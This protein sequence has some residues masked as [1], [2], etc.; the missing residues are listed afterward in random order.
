[1]A[2]VSLA[3]QKTCTRCGE[4]KAL[5]EFGTFQE[6]CG[7]DKRRERRRTECK[8]CSAL[9]C[10]ERRERRRA[11]ELQIAEKRWTT[12]KPEKRCYICTETKAIDQF[13]RVNYVTSTG[14]QSWR[15]DSKC[16]ECRREYDRQRYQKNI[17]HEKARQREYTKT[18]RQERTAAKRRYDKRNPE[19]L[20]LWRRWRWSREKERTYGIGVEAYD[21]FMKRQGEYCTVCGATGD[22]A[23]LCIDH[24]HRTGQ[25]R[26][27]LCAGC[28]LALG[29]IQEDAARARK[30]ALYIEEYCSK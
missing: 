24:C 6:V 23:R 15:F 1:M 20:I 16:L 21:A 14:K 8:I 4:C 22:M 26:G 28:N 30:L 2:D 5:S 18:H 17:E 10:K 3:E 7:V 25:L 27:V 19:K 11:E 9:R 29:N 13:P 12:V